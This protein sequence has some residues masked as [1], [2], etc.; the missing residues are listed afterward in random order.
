[1]ESRKKLEEKL[2]CLEWRIRQSHQEYCQLKNRNA[3]KIE[4]GGI[5]LV[6]RRKYAERIELCKQ[7]NIDPYETG[8]DGL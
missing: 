6:L 5:Q 8:P 1:M 3:K 2:A 4:Y 7:L